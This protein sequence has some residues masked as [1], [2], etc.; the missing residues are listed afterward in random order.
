MAASHGTG[1]RGVGSVM[2]LTQLVDR[3]PGPSDGPL[4]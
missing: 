2:R 1:A 4:R 3:L